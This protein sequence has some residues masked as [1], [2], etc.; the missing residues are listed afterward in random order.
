MHGAG[1]NA[2][3][4]FC[5]LA[6]IVKTMGE[7]EDKTFIYAPRMEYKADR[8]RE[9]E[10]E[11]LVR[12]AAY[13]S[14]YNF[15]QKSENMILGNSIWWNGSKINGDWKAGADADPRSGDMISSFDVFDDLL[16]AAN[17]TSLFPNIKK[18]TLLG[19]SAGGQ[20]IHR[21]ALTGK[22]IEDRFAT[23]E[24]RERGYVLRKGLELVYYV[25]NQSSFTYLNNYRFSYTCKPGASKC[26]DMEYRKY[27]PS[28]GRQ[29]WDDKIGFTALKQN[30]EEK[31]FVC[32]STAAL[33]WPYAVNL[34]QINSGKAAPYL[35][36]HWNLTRSIEIYG[37]KAVRYLSGQWDTCTD[38]VLPFCYSNCWKKEQKCSG[39]HIDTRCPAM[40]QG[41]NRNQRAQNYW[42]HLKHVYGKDLKH[43][44]GEVPGTGHEGEAMFEHAVPLIEEMNK[45]GEIGRAKKIGKAM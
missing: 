22:V 13:W 16:Y 42:D 3:D 30:D 43:I 26:T 41:P 23:Q 28:L 39:T 7:E 6:K 21:Y 36:N 14:G 37:L 27:T 25:A 34:K 33:E 40:L 38:K 44:W 11:S 18:V 24:A 4:Y 1:R 10:K 17:D 35:K 45:L 32:K 2:V 29:G 19:H 15:Y 5:S 31:P 20:T 12:E 8:K 9:S